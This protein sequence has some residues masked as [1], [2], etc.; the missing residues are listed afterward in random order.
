M[1]HV[2]RIERYRVKKMPQ[3]PDRHHILY[4]RTAWESNTN[5][6]WLRE[7]SGLIVRIGQD[8]HA[9]LHKAISVVPLLDHNAAVR[10]RNLMRKSNAT[11]PLDIADDFMSAVQEAGRNPKANRLDRA[12]GEL[13]IMAVEGQREYIEDGI[14]SAQIFDLGAKQRRYASYDDCHIS[15][16]SA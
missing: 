7:E 16:K 10:V 3:Y 6:K 14:T 9:E 2:P 12:L 13:V 4:N 5:T 11:K 8:A 1:E 15:Q